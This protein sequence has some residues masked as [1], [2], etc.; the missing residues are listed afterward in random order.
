MK[1]FTIIM[2][3][4]IA[5]IL[6]AGQ[7]HCSPFTGTVIDVNAAV[8]TISVKDK[9]RTVTFDVSNPVLKG[10]RSIAGIRV[11]DR[12]AL[13]Y[14]RDGIS[15][16]KLSGKGSRAEVERPRAKPEPKKSKK[17]GRIRVAART[18]G[19]DFDDVDENKDGKVSPVELSVIL[20]SLTLEDFRKHDKN[21]DGY[22]N[23][24]EFKPIKRP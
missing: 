13:A 10:Y 4:L 22:L 15:I 17:E 16:T 1:R 9:G 11:G 23:R 24:S 2:F 19:T 18:Q 8:Q 5:V 6:F 20:P 12:I 7:V 14:T 21:G 3:S